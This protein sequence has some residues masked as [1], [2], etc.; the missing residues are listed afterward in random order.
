[1][2]LVRLLAVPLPS[3]NLGQVVHTH[4]PLSPRHTPGRLR[5]YMESLRTG[6]PSSELLFHSLPARGRSMKTPMSTA[7]ISHRLWENADDYG[8]FTL[9]I[10][11][12]VHSSQTQQKRHSWHMTVSKAYTC[13]TKSYIIFTL[14]KI[15]AAYVW[16]HDDVTNITAQCYGNSHKLF[17]TLYAV[18]HL[19]A[20]Y[21]VSDKK[22]TP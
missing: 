9:G 4:V 17:V 22:V 6:P 11:L 19:H 8:W 10:H 2:S 18:P 3:N 21:T 20:K 16:R 15:A 7:R 1:M 13:I 5:Q 12:P 14:R